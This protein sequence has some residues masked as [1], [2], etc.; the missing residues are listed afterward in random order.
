M[1]FAA[2]PTTSLRLK[3]SAQILAVI[4]GLI[5]LFSMFHVEGRYFGAAPRDP[6]SSE[7]RIYPLHE[8][9]TIAYLTQS[10]NQKVHFWR[11]A[12]VACWLG[13]LTC[14]LGAFL[15]RDKSQPIIRTE[16]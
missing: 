9:G 4:G 5:W 12:F 15:T 13:G 10:E 8:R 3:L 7:G 2:R 6:Q 1:I 16:G 14:S 11:I